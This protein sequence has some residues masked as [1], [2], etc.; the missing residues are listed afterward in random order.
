MQ[1]LEEEAA[2]V[3]KKIAHLENKRVVISAKVDHRKEDE[4]VVALEVKLIDNDNDSE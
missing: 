1:S 2:A 4:D 3:E